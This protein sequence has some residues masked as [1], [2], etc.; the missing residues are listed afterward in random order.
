MN[1]FFKINLIQISDSESDQRQ[2]LLPFYYPFFPPFEYFQP[3]T[4][5]TRFVRERRGNIVGETAGVL[6]KSK[7]ILESLVSERQ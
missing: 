1:F 6:G 3:R 2:Q 7:E 5:S 4:R